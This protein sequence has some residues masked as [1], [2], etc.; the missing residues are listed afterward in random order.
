MLESKL[1]ILGIEFIKFIEESSRL[2]TL[3][4]SNPE[5]PTLL[6]ELQEKI[7]EVPIQT[8]NL[9]LNKIDLIE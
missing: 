9:T 4:L 6:H 8:I 3:E 2:K 5:R 7:A 1:I